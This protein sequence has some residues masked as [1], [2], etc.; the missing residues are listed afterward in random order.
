MSG[1]GEIEG[2]LR[3]DMPVAGGSDRPRNR[4]SAT[5]LESGQP[6]VLAD[7]TGRTWSKGNRNRMGWFSGC[8]VF[9]LRI[10]SASLALK[11][12]GRATI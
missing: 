11:P 8:H 5:A 9:S 1:N 4:R 12:H 3:V 7:I 10:A 2:Q 6:A